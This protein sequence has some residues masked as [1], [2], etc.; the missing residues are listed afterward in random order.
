MHETG[1]NI[2]AEDAT[3]W[4][5]TFISDHIMSFYQ[6]P[7]YHRYVN[8]ADPLIP[9]R[10]HKLFLQALQWR[11]PQRRWFGKT[12]YHLGNLPKLFEVYPDARVVHTHRDPLRSMASITS[13][14]RAFFWQ[15]S[16]RDFDAPGFSE[17]MLAEPTSQRLYHAMDLRDRGVVPAAQIADSRY[18]DLLDDPVNAMRRTQVPDHVG[19]AGG[20]RPPVF[21][22][23]SGALSGSGRG[24]RRGRASPPTPIESFRTRSG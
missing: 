19:G 4:C 17:I 2:P 24:L 14:L 1:W 8:A 12:L 22:A 3:I 7:S 23:L 18:Q 21:P 15:R 9:Y 16:D 20:S 5:P 6:I 11:M 13:L 10:F